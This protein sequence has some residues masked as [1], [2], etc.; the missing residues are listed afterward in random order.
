MTDVPDDIWSGRTVLL[1][2]MWDWTPETWGTVGF[3]REGRRA[4]VLRLVSDPFIAVCTIT[5][6]KSL[7]DS[8]L[9]GQV[10]GFY[11]LNHETGDRDAFTDP[12]LHDI[13]PEKWRHSI[14]AV[15]A[16]TYLPEYRIGIR[17]LDPSAIEGGRARSIATNGE[18]VDDPETLRRLRQIPYEEVEVYDPMSG[19]TAAFTGPSQVDGMVRGGPASRDGYQVAG[20]T[21]RLPRLLYVL[22]LA[23]DASAFLGKPADG[24]SIY[25]VGLSYSP[26]M[27]RLTLQKAMPLGA[28]RWEVERT[29]RTDGDASYAGHAIA[30]AGEDAM[31]RHL[32]RH[33]DWLGGEFYL[34]G[35]DAIE[36]AWAAG[37]LAAREAGGLS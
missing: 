36:Q 9:R 10:A 21:D 28:F 26:Q 34:A 4:N 25:K 33:A 14:Q 6:G 7:F 2:S 23:G 11:L 5:S 13:E 17:D 27:R 18:I 8:N 3:T 15:R 32:S 35:A 24:R 16:F 12:V 1:T 22:R 30:M 31:K 20:G 37:R 29:T 19:R